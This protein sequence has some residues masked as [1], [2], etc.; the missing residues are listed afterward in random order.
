MRTYEHLFFDLDNTLWDF[1]S[2]SK[3]A[4]HQTM[5]KI[6]ILPQL[7]SFD[8]YF[9]VY[10]QINKSLWDEYHSKKID[11]KTLI[12]ERFARSLQKFGVS[13]LN[14]EEINREYL[15]FMALQTVLFPGTIDSLR[16]LQAKGYQMHIITNGF[17]EVQNEKI[18]NCELSGFFQKVFISEE[19]KTNKPHR[20]IFEHALKSTNAKKRKSIMIGDSWDTDIRGAMDF[21]LD[22]IM[23]LNEGQN[24]L[25]ESIYSEQLTIN[26]AFLLLKPPSKTYFIQKLKDLLEI[27]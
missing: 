14:W 2:N 15:E 10:E 9:K 17:T 5:E 4:M 1:T 7:D 22:Q 21:G 27:L 25:P 24:E 26:G 19:V 3:V 16:V 23:F 11:K 13:K 12:V 8:T 20:E 6:G 18:K